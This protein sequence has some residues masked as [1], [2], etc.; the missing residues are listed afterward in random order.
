MEGGCSV[1]HADSFRASGRNKPAL[2]GK[3]AGDANGSGV[4]LLTSTTLQGTRAKTALQPI[5]KRLA[6]ALY[7]TKTR[8][9]QAMNITEAVRNYRRYRTA[10]N[11][12]R[13]MSNRELAD[14][15]ITRDSIRDVARGSR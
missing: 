9:N 13:S 14:L 1:G 3:R 4:G 6:L 10:V 2:Q 8:K 7:E 11:E 12:L 5:Y 15:G